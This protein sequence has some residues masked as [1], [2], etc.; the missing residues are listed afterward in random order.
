MNPGKDITESIKIIYHTRPII[1]MGYFIS[2]IKSLKLI[3][4]GIT[5]YFSGAVVIIFQ[6]DEYGVYN[7]VML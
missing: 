4:S 7:C 6:A 3:N 1:N 5:K 2:K